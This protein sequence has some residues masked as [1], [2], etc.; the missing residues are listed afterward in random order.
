MIDWAE[1][2]PD[3]YHIKF[4][5]PFV[6]K[7]LFQAFAGDIAPDSGRL[8]AP[9]ADLS[10]TSTEDTLYVPTLLR[11]AEVYFRKSHSW[12]F[13]DAPHRSADL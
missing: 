11:R 2:S 4:P 9:F 12:L 6:Q 1:V 8:H 10:D 3:E 7:R 13:R 5:L